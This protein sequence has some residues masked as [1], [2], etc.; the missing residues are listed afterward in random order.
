MLRAV[1][2]VFVAAGLALDSVLGLAG[3][4]VFDDELLALDG[5]DEELLAV[6]GFA[7]SFFAASLYFSLR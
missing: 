7:D 5:E 2:Q 3:L 1:N 6:E 4:L